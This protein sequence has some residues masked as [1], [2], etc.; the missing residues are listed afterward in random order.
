MN[1]ENLRENGEQLPGKAM[2]IGIRPGGTSPVWI[3]FSLCAS[4]KDF[5]C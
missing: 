2:G 3:S 4:K 1:N 5:V